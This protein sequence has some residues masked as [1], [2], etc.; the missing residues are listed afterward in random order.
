MNDKTIILPGGSGFLGSAVTPCFQQAGFNVVVLTRGSDRESD[1]VRFVHWDGKTLGP[2]SSC[3]DGAV[4]VVNLAGRSVNCR[5]TPHNRREILESRVDAVRVIGQAI[6]RCSTPPKVLIQAASA[7]IHG[8]A[9]DQLLDESSP[10]GL[11]FS[12]QTCVQWEAAFYQTPSPGTRRVLLRI[13]FALGPDGGALGTLAALARLFLGGTVGTGQQWISWLHVKDLSRIIL[14]AI[15]HDDASG[16][17]LAVGPNPVR[18]RQFM[19]ELRRAVHRPWSPPVPAWAVRVGSWLMRTEHELALWG[20]R[21]TPRR[22]ME[23]GFEFEFPELSPT[24][25]NLFPRHGPAA[26]ATRDPHVQPG[27]PVPNRT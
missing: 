10:P 12:P 26:R 16:L 7:A 22:L 3:V 25:E 23:S 9:G 24:L 15:E 11:G 2:W 8:D 21:C 17:Y 14:W 5:Y 4:A 18:N 6:E 1:G 13:G 19:R 20:R 27:V